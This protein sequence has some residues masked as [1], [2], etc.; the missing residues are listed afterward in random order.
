MVT[1]GQP[2]QSV[3]TIAEQL[4]LVDQVMKDRSLPSRPGPRR[5]RLAELG[6]PSKA[7]VKMLT[8]MWRAKAI[9]DRY[10]YKRKWA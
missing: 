10:I 5:R 3:W 7:N 9:K 4:E 6:L 2:I 1:G 8:E